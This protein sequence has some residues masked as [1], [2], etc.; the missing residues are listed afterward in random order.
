[1]PRSAL[2]RL[3]RPRRADRRLHAELF[4]GE[5]QQPSWASQF[6]DIPSGKQRSAHFR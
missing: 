1:M 6:G 5:N 2:A 3:R 4:G